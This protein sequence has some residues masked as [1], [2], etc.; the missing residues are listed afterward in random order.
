VSIN[1]RMVAF[2]GSGNLQDAQYSFLANGGVPVPRIATIAGRYYGHRSTLGWGAANS[3]SL[4]MAAGTLYAV[5][6]WVHEAMAIDRI[7]L[8]VGTASAGNMRLG[9]YSANA[10]GLPDAR[11]LDSGEL[12]TGTIGIKEATVALTLQPGVLYYLVVLAS[13]TPVVSALN[14]TA[15]LF[16]ATDASVV[17]AATGLSRAFA[18]AALPAT[19]GAHT[20]YVTAP[21]YICVRAV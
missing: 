17:P 1:D 13:A 15:S 10:D 9:I 4:P 6:F 21:P 20:A 5:P 11:L 19:F 2:Y 7:A 12:A 8:N 14:S 3:A 16:G 18:Y